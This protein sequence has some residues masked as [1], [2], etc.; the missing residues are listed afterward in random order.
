MLRGKVRCRQIHSY[1]GRLRFTTASFLLALLLLRPNAG[2]GAPVDDQE[3]VQA[4]VLKQESASDNATCLSQRGDLVRCFEGIG[5]FYEYCDRC[6]ATALPARADS[7][8]DLNS[9][10]CAAID[11]C[12]CGL[13]ANEVEHFLNCAFQVLVRCSLNCTD[14]A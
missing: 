8:R 10:M 11:G 3:E 14:A 2:V 1:C 6:V 12:P 4:L 9:V 13:C 7:C 5:S